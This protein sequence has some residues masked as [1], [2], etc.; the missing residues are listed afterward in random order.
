M[1]SRT[2]RSVSAA[3]TL[4]RT[5]SSSSGR[6]PSP[7]TSTVV[8]TSRPASRDANSRPTGP[9][10][11]TMA[12]PGAASRGRSS[13]RVVESCTPGRRAPGMS[14]RSGYAL[15]LT[16]TCSART[17][18]RSPS[19][20]SVAGAG[21][22]PSSGDHGVTST[23][24]SPVNRAWPWTS[25]T[26]SSGSSMAWFAARSRSVRASRKSHA[27]GRAVS[28][29]SP[30]RRSPARWT[31]ALVGA[32]AMLMQVPPTMPGSRSTRARRRPAAPRL[33]A[34]VLPP[35]PQPRIRASTS[36]SGAV[37]ACSVTG[38]YRLVASTLA[39]RH[40][41][42]MSAPPRG[43]ARLSRPGARAGSGSP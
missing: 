20:A 17:T 1:R 14:G 42:V 7:R 40:G 39:R 16:T 32:Q 43:Q 28:G 37:A 5:S 31:R 22:R 34:R 4:S 15:V 41:D 2:P 18:R 21:S 33:L 23:V 11:T 24:H 12:R 6:I 13:W 35:L 10:P 38:R 29:S 30:G 8:S 3:T 19:A 26:L 25:R 9:E 27:A 36:S